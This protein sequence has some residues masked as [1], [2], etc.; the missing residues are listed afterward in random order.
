MVV[1]NIDEADFSYE[2]SALFYVHNNNKSEKY[3]KKMNFSVNNW[4]LN[5]YVISCNLLI[6]LLFQ[7]TIFIQIKLSPFF[8][9]NN[10]QEIA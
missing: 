2:L 8:K 10:L 4:L 6:K 7:Y 5:Y 1:A 9:R 3:Q